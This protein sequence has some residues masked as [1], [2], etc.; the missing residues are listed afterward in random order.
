LPFSNERIKGCI[1]TLNKGLRDAIALIA[2]VHV[3]TLSTVA[4]KAI[5]CSPGLPNLLELNSKRLA[6]AYLDV[7][8]FFKSSDIAYIPCNSA[9]F[10]LAKLAPLA[11]S[12]IEEMA[13]FLQYIQAGVMVAPGWAYHINKSQRGWMRVSFAVN[14]ESLQ[15]GL[16]RIKLVYDKVSAAY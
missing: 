15:K 3:S 1:V 14:N 12:Q 9:I 16:K 10:M 4:S 8:T 2:S 13:A 5:L 6:E 11:K 7:I